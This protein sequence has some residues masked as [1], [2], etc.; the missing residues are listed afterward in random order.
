MQ[1]PGAKS[2]VSPKVVSGANWST[3]ATLILTL[4]G[5]VTPDMLSGLG[6]FAPLVYGL[7]VAASYTL[8]AYLK[9][10]PARDA[11][12]AAQQSA[13]PVPMP[14]APVTPAVGTIVVNSAAPAPVDPAPD[15]AP[16]ET[17]AAPAAT[18]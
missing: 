17:P 2:P 12:L 8:G 15:P 18:N 4:L 11:G 7:V 13:V 10:D 6:H 16:A 3:Y 1:L 9:A 5:F 14:A